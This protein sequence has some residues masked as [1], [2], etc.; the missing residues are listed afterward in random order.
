ME[1]LV[2]DRA[3]YLQRLQQ[4]KDNK[5]AIIWEIAKGQFGSLTKDNEGFCETQYLAL[6]AN[7]E[8]WINQNFPAQQKK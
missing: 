4:I 3:H 5:K 8:N 7:Y 2:K 6:V 1:T